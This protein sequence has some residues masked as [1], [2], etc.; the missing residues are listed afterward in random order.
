MI[1]CLTFVTIKAQCQ[2]MM[3]ELGLLFGCID[4]IVTPDGEYYFLEVNEQ[5]QFLW[6]DDI[7]PSIN[8]LEQF[9]AFLIAPHKHLER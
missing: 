8:M 3:K 2:R 9:C 1:A 7:A 4:L 5:G 6:I